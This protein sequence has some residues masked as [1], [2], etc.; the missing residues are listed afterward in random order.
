[1]L[2]LFMLLCATALLAACASLTEDECRAADWYQIGYADGSEGY[3]P[4]RL[5]S[6]RQACAKI[7]VS[8]DAETWFEGRERGL[9]LYCTPIKAYEVARRG[10]TMRAGCTAAETR[11]L[12]PAFDWGRAYWRLEQ[13]IDDIESDIREI[14]SEI[15][16]L[17]PDAASTRSRLLAERARLSSRL[18]LL[19]SQQDR[20][21]SWP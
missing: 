11:A 3:S 17:P 13:E 9:R 4:D 7:G 15:A 21:A 20:Y 16:A 2:R 8:P 12:M 18:W 6:H 14:D 10:S 19:E 1:M 5:E